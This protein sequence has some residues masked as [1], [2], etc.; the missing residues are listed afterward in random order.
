MQ[1]NP[2]VSSML[3]NQLAVSRAGTALQAA[4]VRG[5]IALLRSLPDDTQE[6]PTFSQQAVSALMRVFAMCANLYAGGEAAKGD[7]RIAQSMQIM[8]DIAKALPDTTPILPGGGAPTIGEHLSKPDRAI[9]YPGLEAGL[10]EPIVP[11]I[12][13]PLPVA[14]AEAVH[15]AEAPRSSE[16]AAVPGEVPAGAAR[17]TRVLGIPFRGRAPLALLQF[18]AVWASIGFAALFVSEH[19]FSLLSV[20]I[21]EPAVAA[22]AVAFVLT[23]AG[24]LLAAFLGA[25]PGFLRGIG[26]FLRLEVLLALPPAAALA[27]WPLFPAMEITQW[28]RLGAAG[29][30]VFWVI[31]TFAH[32]R[33]LTGA[34][35]FWHGLLRCIAIAAVLLLVFAA[36][37][38]AFPAWPLSVSRL[39]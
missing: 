27:A 23:W 1:A 17:S 26:R 6:A 20:R 33:M 31:A 29:Y 19:F 34:R 25:L 5:V 10:F 35:G 3:L 24:L 11:P 4:R 30:L 21:S 32:V 22:G 8:R 28:H 12:R 15:T 38:W 37:V 13:Q 2:A 39:F 16:A 14:Q 18:I 7:P 36:S 9:E